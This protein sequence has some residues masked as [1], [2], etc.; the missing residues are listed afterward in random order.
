VSISCRSYSGR[1]DQKSFH[2]KVQHIAEP[3][4]DEA[5]KESRHRN[6]FTPSDKI[7]FERGINL[8]PRHEGVWGEWGCSSMQSQPKHYGLCRGNSAVSCS[9]R[10]AQVGEKP[11]L[12]TA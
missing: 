10:F 2:P 12:P 9:G 3:M 6:I 4:Y 8:A 1:R 5:C 7:K 11:S